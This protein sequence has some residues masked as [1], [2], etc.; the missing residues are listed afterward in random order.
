MKCEEF[1][2]CGDPDVVDVLKDEIKFKYR[3]VHFDETVLFGFFYESRAR[4]WGL[5]CGVCGLRHAMESRSYG[6][7]LHGSR[8][9]RT[10]RR[11]N[12]SQF[13]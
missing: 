9:R 2:V 4:V 11:K 5:E 3:F 8:K 12:S 6:T 13:R 10:A 7:S 1:S